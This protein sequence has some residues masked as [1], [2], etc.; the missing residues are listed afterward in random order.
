VRG[1]PGLALLVL[2][3]CSFHAGT[4]PIDSPGSDVDVPTG[5]IVEGSGGSAF[6]GTVSGGVVAARD[7]LEPDV[8]V[9]GGL[10]ALGYTSSAGLSGSS[11]ADGG[12]ALGSAA[13][14]SYGFVPVGVWNDGGNTLASPLGVGLAGQK[15]GWAV[16]L[17]GEIFLGSGATTL[18]AFGDDVAI[19]EIDADMPL[20]L[21]GSGGNAASG[22]ASAGSAGWFP[23]H[24]LVFNNAGSGS[25]E[26]ALGSGSNAQPFDA[27]LLRARTTTATG[28]HAD[29]AFEP[30]LETL[31]FL[32][33][34]AL[35][36]SIDGSAEPGDWSTAIPNKFSVR[37]SGQL[38]VDDG[39]DHA[40]G[41]AVGSADHYRLFVDNSLVAAAWLTEPGAPP[42]GTAGSATL[43]L[44]PGWHAVVLDYGDGGAG[45]GT[46]ALDLDGS[47][48]DGGHLRPTHPQGIVGGISA[49]GEQTPCTFTTA[50][51]ASCAVS[52]FELS[53]GAV[54]DY[55]D[56]AYQLG[57]GGKRPNVAAA[58]VAGS[59]SVPLSFAGAAPDEQEYGA[60]PAFDYLPSQTEVAELGG[61]ATWSLTM[62]DALENGNL[63]AL[64]TATIHGGDGAPFSASF[65]YTSQPYMLPTGE[66]ITGA[67]VEGELVG[68]TVVVEIATAADLTSLGTAAFQPVG[69]AQI[70]VDELVAFR[71]VVTTDGWTFPFVSRVEIDYGAMGT[72]DDR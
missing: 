46:I 35:V 21:V 61:S 13:G 55:L 8:F 38:L 39:G 27:L 4:A 31:S 45:G 37:Y 44:A 62:R 33:A 72:S 63:W 67:R 36:P 66:F 50:T 26:L 23:I 11:S 14:E 12:S 69:S 6:G 47:A 7:V 1:H 65:A 57:G 41:V 30:E 29:V 3:A 70:P 34:T 10:H 48:V 19:V 64:A 20:R 16:A 18:S 5:S 68:A 60:G 40:V 17:D 52:F 22:V 54:F 2:G 53:A 56:V 49:G 71:V 15:T 25:L 42:V 32:P 51:A 9:P 28:M 43:S 24:A 59:A 58:I